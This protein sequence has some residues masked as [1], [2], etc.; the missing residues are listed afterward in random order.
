M[1]PHY[2]AK[3]L[4]FSQQNDTALFYS[5]PYIKNYWSVAAPVATLA[6]SLVRFIDRKTSVYKSTDQWQC[7][8]Y[9][10]K[11]RPL[12]T[13]FLPSIHWRSVCLLTCLCCPQAKFPEGFQHK[14]C[15][16]SALP[17]T[18]S[19]CFQCVAAQ[20]ARSA[21]CRWPGAAPQERATEC[22]AGGRKN[23]INY[24]ETKIWNYMSG[25]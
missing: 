25:F 9:C 2:W 18:H 11:Y 23:F 3:C 14:G 7:A 24:V 5:V 16:L 17:S 6:Y 1:F 4:Q 15:L 12:F 20:R 19:A 22:P 21:L 13:F 10:G 8:L